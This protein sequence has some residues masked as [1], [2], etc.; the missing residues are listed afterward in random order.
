MDGQRKELDLAGIVRAM[1][2]VNGSVVHVHAQEALHD[3][4]KCLLEVVDLAQRP[5][6]MVKRGEEAIPIFNQARLLDF[7]RRAQTAYSVLQWHEGAVLRKCAG[8][9]PFLL[10]GN[11][12]VQMRRRRP[13]RS[14]VC[15]RGPGAE[16]T[17]PNVHLAF[18]KFQVNHGDG[19]AK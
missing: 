11:Q 14:R 18:G 6:A 8:L 12:F 17:E 16:V 9:N 5:V 10:K 1:R 7:V 4:D 15:P 3:L 2:R 13:L 19:H